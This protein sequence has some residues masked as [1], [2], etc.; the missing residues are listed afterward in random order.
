LNLLYIAVGFTP[1][2]CGGVGRLIRILQKDSFERYQPLAF[3][4][5]EQL[6]WIDECLVSEQA[7]T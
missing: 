4:T 1:I 2:I 7:P 3:D 6:H 5:V